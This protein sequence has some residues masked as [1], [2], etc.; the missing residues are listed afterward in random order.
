MKT[1]S[2][3]LLTPVKTRGDAFVRAIQSDARAGMVADGELAKA[4]EA[5]WIACREAAASMRKA[6]GD[7]RSLGTRIRALQPPGGKAK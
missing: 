4:W 5:G 2:Y 3:W 1:P 7:E 6:P